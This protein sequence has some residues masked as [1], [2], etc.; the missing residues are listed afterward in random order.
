MSR[1]SVPAAIRELEEFGYYPQ[2]SAT[3]RHRALNKAIRNGVSLIY[4]VD[5]FSMS[6]SKKIKYSKP[7]K[8]DYEWL[9]KK[10]K[11]KQMTKNVTVLNFYITSPGK[12]CPKGYRKKKGTNDLCVQRK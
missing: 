5:L 11:Y 2:K 10:P 8:E 4:L 1:T 3:S 7:Y 12:R 9:E 6:V